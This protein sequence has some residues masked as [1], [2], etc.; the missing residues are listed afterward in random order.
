M[1]GKQS[2]CS[3]QS[4]RVPGN[5]SSR[6]SFSSGE[7]TFAH[8]KRATASSSSSRRWQATAWFRAG[9][10]GRR[11][12]TCSRERHF[13]ALVVGGLNSVRT[14]MEVGKLRY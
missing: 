2:S 5:T 3:F 7:A 4:S 14:G 13:L 11:A 6:T 9:M 1:M 8:L 12:N 10:H